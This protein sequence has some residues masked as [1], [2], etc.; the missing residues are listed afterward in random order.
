LRHADY[1]LIAII[2]PCFSPYAISPRRATPIRHAFHAY[3]AIALRPH[4][5][6]LFAYAS[7]AMLPRLMPSLLMR[8]LFFFTPYAAATISAHDGIAA[9]PLRHAMLDSDTPRRFY[10]LRADDGFC[11]Q[12]R[13]CCCAS[14]A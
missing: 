1:L 11:R 12:I 3:E 7:Y 5:I 6:T 13:R 9:M 4:T 2:L 10:A 8:R 14:H